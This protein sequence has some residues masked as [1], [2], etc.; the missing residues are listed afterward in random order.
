MN[1]EQLKDMQEVVEDAKANALRFPEISSDDLEALV[2]LGFECLKLREQ[3]RWIP[4]SERLPEKDGLYDVVVRSTQNK[5][6]QRRAS[7]ILFLDG[8]FDFNASASCEYVSHWRQLSGL[9][10]LPTGEQA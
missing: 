6:Y 2:K 9:P 10:E 5:D 3:L 8:T 1:A 4:V 7:S